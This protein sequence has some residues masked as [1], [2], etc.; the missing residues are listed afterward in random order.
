M[1]AEPIYN[2]FRTRITDTTQYTYDY[3][4]V[5]DNH[6]FGVNVQHLR[7][8]A[9]DHKGQFGTNIETGRH[10]SCVP[11]PQCRTIAL[12]TDGLRLS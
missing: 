12:P 4:S 8:V 6:Q 7:N 2:R 11:H 10:T 3:S 9:G 5:I 1:F